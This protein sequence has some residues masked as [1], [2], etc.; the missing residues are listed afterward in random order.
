MIEKRRQV[1]WYVVWKFL[2][3]AS[4]RGDFWRGRVY[5]SCLGAQVLHL[6]KSE[7]NCNPESY[8]FIVVLLIWAKSFC[9]YKFLHTP[10]VLIHHHFL[11]WLCILG[12]RTMGC[13]LHTT[14]N[15]HPLCYSIEFYLVHLTQSPCIMAYHTLQA[16]YTPLPF[17]FFI[18]FFFNSCLF[19][20]TFY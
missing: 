2:T 1:G 19:L 10:F 3:I 11:I 6:N 18:P 20:N 14:T 8:P 16:H 17:S 9:P 12:F 7:M 4:F 15:M 13:Y 5:D